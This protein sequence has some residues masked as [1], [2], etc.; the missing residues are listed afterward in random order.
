[1]IS[2]IIPVYNNAL[3]L[4]ELTTQIDFALSLKHHYEIIFIDDGSTDNSMTTLRSLA[5]KNSAI[6]ILSLSRNFG[7]HPAISAGFEYASGEKIVL[8]DADLQDN[9]IYLPEMITKLKD[10]I[11]IVYTMKVY[12]SVQ[13]NK[14]T[15]RFF[16]YVFSKIVKQKNLSNIGTYRAF[17]RKFLNA[18]LK[19]P[20]RN[21]VY[22]PLMHYMGF[23]S[24]II[25]V[26]HQ[27]RKNRSSYTFSK[28][29]KLSID[30]L[31]SYTNIPHLSFIW[32]GLSLFAGSSIY[33]VYVVITYLL[34]GRVLLSGITLILVVLLLTLGSIMISLGIMG[35]YI[36]RIFQEVLRRPRYL[37]KESINLPFKD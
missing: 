10:N 35:N 30:S 20:E 18:M 3:T 4:E 22:G 12:S 16:H 28:R 29:L 24:E 27:K 14:I 5:Q 19:Y 34:G 2:I 13:D 26:L 8:M 23:H 11:D 21:I 6:K 17:T 36:F 9:P 33:C 32:F 1:M 25:P 15:S 7:Q 37:I 31:V